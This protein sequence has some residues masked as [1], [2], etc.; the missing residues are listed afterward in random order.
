MRFI[1]GP[2]KRDLCLATERPRQANIDPIKDPSVFAL[3]LPLSFSLSN[4]NVRESKKSISLVSTDVHGLFA[5]RV[6]QATFARSLS[7][8]EKAPLDL[9]QQ[10]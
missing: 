7:L 1:S 10:N 4:C 3:S 5:R 6:T 2:K 9:K 8:S